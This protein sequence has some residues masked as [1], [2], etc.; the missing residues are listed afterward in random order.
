M[1]DK[2]L[3]VHCMQDVRLPLPEDI[4]YLSRKTK[5]LCLTAAGIWH[6][7]HLRNADT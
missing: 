6:P 2:Q 3:Y 1:P 5:G 7:T 4:G